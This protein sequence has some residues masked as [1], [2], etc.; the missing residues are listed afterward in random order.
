LGTTSARGK[1]SAVAG[2]ITGAAVWGL[3]WY[4]FR[5]L[6][7]AGVPGVL[8]TLVSYAIALAAA[9]PLFL[10]DLGALLRPDRWLVGI[11]LSA[12]WCNLAYVLAMIHGQVMQVLL[13]FYLAPLWT[14]LFARALLDER[15]GAVGYVV[16]ALSLAGALLMLWQPQGRLPVPRT[17]AEWLGL[18]SGLAFALSNVL[19]RRAGHQS[20]SVKS[21]AVFAGVVLVALLVAAIEPTPAVVSNA[22]EAAG[23]L[24]TLGL[25]LLA[26][27][28][29]VQHGLTSVP[30]NRAIVIMLCEL[31]FAAVS[32]HLLAAESMRWNEWAGGALI[33]AA[34][35]LSGKLEAA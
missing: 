27:N 35:L 12:G 17:G 26:T 16:I 13:L 31:L 14:V 1:R 29:A 30:A 24:L 23:L 9:V 19:S 3:M 20:V 15:P 6:E 32:A 7:E 18:T 22:P 5:V 25:V 8:A 21:T 10:R 28:L 11:A 34:S 2:L 33:V 4:P